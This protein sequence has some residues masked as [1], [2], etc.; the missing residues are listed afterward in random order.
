MIV[1]DELSQKEK[2]VVCL[3]LA[4]MYRT[5]WV[6]E[7][8]R[9]DGSDIHTAWKGYDFWVLNML[10]DLDLIDSG[11][12]RSNKSASFTEKGEEIARRLAESISVD[13]LV[14]DLFKSLEALEEEK[15]FDSAE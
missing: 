3:T 12:R 14:S 6:E 8:T 4:L 2:E 1:V 7:M 5:S 15:A 13:E 10:E 9:F 11:K